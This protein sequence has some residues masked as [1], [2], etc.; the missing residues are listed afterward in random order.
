PSNSPAAR[1]LTLRKLR[2]ARPE[3]GEGAGARAYTVCIFMHMTHNYARTIVVKYGGGAMPASPAG[4]ADPVLSE[5]AGLCAAGS[6]VVLVHGGGPE[7][8][9]ALARRGVQTLRID[10]MRVT[11]AATLEVTEAVL[12]GSVNKRIVREALA[13]GLAAVGLSG[14]D[15]KM[16]IAERAV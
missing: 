12:C 14:Q 7:I 6:E 8:D 3:N 5:I 13:L 4:Q 1:P 11:D 9:S 2:P 16:L 10:G 15:G